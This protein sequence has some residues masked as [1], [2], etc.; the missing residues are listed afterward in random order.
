MV[1]SPME[2]R[3]GRSTLVSQKAHVFED[4]QKSS[5]AYYNG[6]E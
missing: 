1:P 3:D 4:I 2:K 5:I 6:S